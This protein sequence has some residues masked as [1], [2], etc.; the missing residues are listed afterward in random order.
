MALGPDEKTTT[1]IADL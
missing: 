1:K